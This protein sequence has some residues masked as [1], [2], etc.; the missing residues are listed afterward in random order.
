MR[1]AVVACAWALAANVAAAQPV[2]T[3]GGDV[4]IAPFGGLNLRTDLGTQIVRVGG[5][6]QVDRVAI[7]LVTDPKGYLEDAQH[8]HDLV[9]EWFFRSD[10]WALTGG[11]RLSSLPVLGR[12]Y[13][14]EQALAGLTAPLP[15]LLF[16]AI[17]A[18][19]GAEVV[20]TVARHGRDLPTFWAW[21]DDALRG[22]W[23]NVGLF[24]R[25]QVGGS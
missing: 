10:G 24:A 12:R 17:V 5:G 15:R 8:D 21:E 6:V 2:E 20:V 4:E 13:Y 14:Q 19:A 18:R 23:I 1:G 3:Q 7:H 9:A 16:G 22:G 11:W 25:F